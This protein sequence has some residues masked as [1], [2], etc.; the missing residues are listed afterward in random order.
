MF[1]NGATKM[2]FGIFYLDFEDHEYSTFLIVIKLRK[3]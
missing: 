1:S 3:T 2:E